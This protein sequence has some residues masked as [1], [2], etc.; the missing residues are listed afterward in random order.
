MLKISLPSSTNYFILCLLANKLILLLSSPI[1]K[2]V[3]SKR[4]EDGYR[5]SR[6]YTSYFEA[7]F[8][9]KTHYFLKS[10]LSH[11][12]PYSS[13]PHIIQLSSAGTHTDNSVLGRFAIATNYIHI[14]LE[15]YSVCPLVGIGTPPPSSPANVCA[16]PS[17][18]KGGGGTHHRVHIFLEMKQ[19]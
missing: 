5:T 15:Y 18:T 16:T 6:L 1:R 13:L 11:S 10:A 17:R 8:I 7:I 14:Y 4:T 19:G 3:Q 9:M 2:K 12:P